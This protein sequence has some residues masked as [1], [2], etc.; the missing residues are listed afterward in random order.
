MAPAPA[1]LLKPRRHAWGLLAMALMAGAVVA[2]IWTSKAHP[3]VDLLGYPYPGGA[4]DADQSKH[5]L[6]LSVLAMLAVGGLF[7]VVAWL[8]DLQSAQMSRSGRRRFKREAA[9]RTDHGAG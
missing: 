3:G 2:L 1:P 6:L 8:A 9:R 7:G 4:P 5:R